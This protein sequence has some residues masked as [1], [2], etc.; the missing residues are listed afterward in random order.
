MSNSSRRDWLKSAGLYSLAAT[1][2]GRLPANDRSEEAKTVLDIGSRRELFVDH[3]LIDRL[4]GTRLELHHPQ[5]AEG[6]FKLDRP[7]E[8]VYCG[9]TTVFQDED[10]YRM[11]YLGYPVDPPGNYTCYAESTDGI[12]WT[13][14]DLGLVEFQ[15]SKSNNILL[16]GLPEC[17]NFSPFLDAKPGV[18]EAERYKAVGGLPPKGLMAYSSPDGVHWKKMKEQGIITQGAF[19]SHNVAFYSES[20]GCYVCYFRTFRNGIRWIDRCT[21]DDFLNWTEPVAMDF[22]DAPPEHHYT[23]STTPYFR[24]PHISIALPSRFM[25]GK[26]AVSQ[27][28]K[29][30]LGVEGGYLPPGSGFNDMPLMTSR[31]G[32]RYQRT[33]LETFIEPGIGYENWTSRSCYPAFGIVPTPDSDTQLSM[34][35]N[36]HTGYPSAHLA[37]YTLRYDGFVSVHAPFAGGEL[38][39]KPL[40]FEGDRLSINDK[41]SA[42]GAVRVEIQNAAGQ[43]IPG[44]TLADSAEIIGDE[45]DRTVS[46]ANGSDVSRLAGQPVRLRFVM[47]AADL[48][49][50]QFGNR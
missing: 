30:E 13:R 15:G 8:G 2:A 25:A 41:T 47:K 34:Y 14:P 20:E 29:D 24:A 5:L 18:P 45:L 7:W 9:Y 3:F 42:P 10:R 12:E 1:S 28:M 39:T 37:R 22:G 31:G 27:E 19:D 17:H 11:Y 49:A 43:P 35:V 50:L 6:A 40:T 16:A 36:R 38:V 46:W 4:E 26:D 21:S 48:Y 23:N 32:N 44:F 33:F